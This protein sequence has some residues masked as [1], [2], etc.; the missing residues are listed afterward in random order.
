MEQEDY[1][2]KRK[3]LAEFEEEIIHRVAEIGDEVLNNLFLN[4]QNL[5]L[6]LNENSV[7]IMEELL[8]KIDEEVSIKD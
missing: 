8:G 6:E 5:R 1:N 4:W 7:K 3:Q 2:E